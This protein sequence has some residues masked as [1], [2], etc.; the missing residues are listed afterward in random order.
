MF[1]RS[2]AEGDDLMRYMGM[3]AAVAAS[4][5]VSITGACAASA[6]KGRVAFREKG[7]WQCHGY[8]GQG[9]ANGLTLARTQLP[10]EAVDAFV[11]NTDGPMPPFSKKVLSDEDLADIYAFLSAQPVPADPKTIPLLAH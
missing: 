3:I 5:L 7:C 9:G 1:G 2:R 6:E 10:L 8:E 4:L 11:R